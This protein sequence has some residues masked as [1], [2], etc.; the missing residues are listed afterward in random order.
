MTELQCKE[1][2]GNA[3][4]IHFYSIIMSVGVSQHHLFR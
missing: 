2:K 3:G 1:T 4:D